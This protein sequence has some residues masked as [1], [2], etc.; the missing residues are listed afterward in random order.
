MCVSDRP[1]PLYII[2]LFPLSICERPC[3]DEKRQTVLVLG[4]VVV[5]FVDRGKPNKAWGI[6]NQRHVDYQISSVA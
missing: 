5:S 3:H 1:P 6:C 4:R 2:G